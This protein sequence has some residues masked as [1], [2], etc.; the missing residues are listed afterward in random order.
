MD[1]VPSEDTLVISAR[2]NP[3]DRG[4]VHTGQKAVVKIDTYDFSR[5]GGI[6]G[7]VIS[8]APDS[9]ISNTGQSYFKVMI[10]T[11][12]P[13]LG[14]EFEGL[15][16]SPGMGATIDIHT[17]TKSVLSYLIKPIIKL[18]TEAFRER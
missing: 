3:M 14:E 10:S 11:K 9:T 2:L 13:W 8:V 12:E 7:L 6:E 17:G 5:Y 15:L 1:I 16:I 4:F 18:R